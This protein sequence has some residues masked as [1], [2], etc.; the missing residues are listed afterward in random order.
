MG[1]QKREQYYAEISYKIWG[2]F[3]IF[4]LWDQFIIYR[5]WGQFIILKLRSQLATFEG[6]GANL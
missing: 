5:K 3:I 2:L 1:Y 6:S 4:K